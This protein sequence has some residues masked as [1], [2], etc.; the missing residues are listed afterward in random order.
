MD[1]AGQYMD[2]V[3]L[4]LMGELSAID[5]LLKAPSPVDGEVVERMSDADDDD[6]DEE[7]VAGS[8]RSPLVTL[9]KPKLIVPPGKDD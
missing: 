6:E 8:T 7:V 2:D 3:E 4:G 5:T 1:K 9:T